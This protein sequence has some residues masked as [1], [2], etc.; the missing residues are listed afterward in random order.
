MVG[1]RGGHVAVRHGR[2]D[3]PMRHDLITRAPPAWPSRR[4]GD[5]LREEGSTTTQV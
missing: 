5:P 1:R 2:S 4:W 3:T